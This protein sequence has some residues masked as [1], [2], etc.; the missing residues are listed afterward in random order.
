MFSSGSPSNAPVECKTLQHYLINSTCKR[1]P[2]IEP[3]T[4]ENDI[5]S[6]TDSSHHCASVQSEFSTKLL[7]NLNSGMPS[8]WELN[9]RKERYQTG[10]NPS[11]RE[12]CGHTTCRDTCLFETYQTSREP[13]PDRD[14]GNGED[15]KPPSLS[16][17]PE[18]Q[19]EYRWDGPPVNTQGDLQRDLDTQQ[20]EPDD[21]LSGIDYSLSQLVEAEIEAFRVNLHNLISDHHQQHRQLLSPGNEAVTEQRAVYDQPAGNGDAN[22]AWSPMNSSEKPQMEE[23]S[24]SSYSMQD[25][26]TIQL[27]HPNNS[28]EDEVNSALLQLLTSASAVSHALR[29]HEYST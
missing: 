6:I 1:A 27:Y 20:T 8:D 29:R 4:M 16:Y 3:T 24:S 10:L 13:T 21:V 26:E 2:S 19:H 11:L 18:R 5:L 14:A 17:L 9:K 22:Y 12:F 7:A 23:S 25:E 15:G 28:L